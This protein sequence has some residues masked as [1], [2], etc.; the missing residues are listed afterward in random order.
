[1]TIRSFRWT[2]LFT[3][4]LFS[5]SSLF[6]SETSILVSILVRKG[7][8][9]EDE[10]QAVLEEASMVAQMSSPR[11]PLEHQPTVA[12]SGL[13]PEP[14]K[15]PILVIPDSKIASDFKIGGRLQ[16]QY[17]GISTDIKGNDNDPDPTR[18]FFMRRLYLTI[19]AKFGHQWSAKVTYDMPSSGFDAAY[20]RYEVND[21]NRFDFGLRKVNFAY[22]ETLSSGSLKALERSGATRYFVEPFNGRRLGAGSYRVGVFYDGS[23]GSLF[24]GGAITNPEG[25]RSAIGAASSGVDSNNGLALWANGGYTVDYDKGSA[26]LGASVGYL[27]DQG[28]TV[29]IGENLF[30][31]SVYAAAGMGDWRLLTEL[32][33]ADTGPSN[34]W[35]IVLQPSAYFTPNVEGVFRFSYV[36]SGGRGIRT[37]DGIRSAP[38]GG[39]MNNLYECYVGANWYMMGNNLKLQGGIIF[40]RSE[41]TVDGGAAE[42][43]VLGIRSQLQVNF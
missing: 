27:Q 21:G 41:D 20:V 43:N 12:P 14:E 13:E 7:I 32:L 33:L 11:A 38:S 24:Y 25:P 9:A 15:K 29:G 6:A 30:V 17:A 4:F 22:E 26:V 23:S 2:V 10:A 42:A 40:G 3:T 8:L 16:V 34:P 28:T 37:S 18:H 1:M 35:S 19:K 36:D 31:G 39:T 5:F